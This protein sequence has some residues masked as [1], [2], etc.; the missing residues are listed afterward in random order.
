MQRGNPLIIGRS[1]HQSADRC[2][3]TSA[4]WTAFVGL[5]LLLLALADVLLVGLG[6]CLTLLQLFILFVQNF[7]DSLVLFGLTQTVDQGQSQGNIGDGGNGQTLSAHHKTHLLLGAF[8]ADALLVGAGGKGLCPAPG[9]V[10]S[11]SCHIY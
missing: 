2:A 8:Q 11:V 4:L 5:N 1:P 7:Q 9:V 10:G 3:M 6:F